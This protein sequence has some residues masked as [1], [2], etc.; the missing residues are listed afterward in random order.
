M[1]RLS[2][3]QFEEITASLLS[4]GNLRTTEK[5]QKPRVGLRCSLDVMLCDESGTP[6]SKSTVWMRDL[7][8]QGVGIVTSIQ[9]PDRSKFVAVFER[10]NRRHLCVLYSVAYCRQLTKGLYSVGAKMERALTTE[11]ALLTGIQSPGNPD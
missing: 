1:Q 8:A 3:E 2:A 7:S 5:R 4:D 6:R 9:F 11:E 10:A